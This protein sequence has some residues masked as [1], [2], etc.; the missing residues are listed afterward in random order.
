MLEERLLARRTVARL[1]AWRRQAGALTV[2]TSTENR[3]S[4]HPRDEHEERS[5]AGLE[6]LTFVDDERFEAQENVLRMT[7][8]AR[9]ATGSAAYAEEI[10]AAI[11]LPMYLT[12]FPLAVLPR[13]RTSDFHAVDVHPPCRGKAEALRVLEERNGIPAARVVAIGD[14][15]NDEPLLRAAGL[16][17]A[18]ANAEAGTRAVADR[19]IGHHDGDSIAALVAEL[20]GV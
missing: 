18:M 5:L 8:L 15:A 2:L 14:A 4:T 7:F 13:H 9:R 10:E 3:L 19:V 16:G 6:G 20:F 17:V 1:H 11:D 12:H